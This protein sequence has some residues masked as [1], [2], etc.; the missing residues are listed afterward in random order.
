MSKEYCPK[1]KE[2]IEALRNKLRERQ[3][4]PDDLILRHAYWN[5]VLADNWKEIQNG[6]GSMPD[7]PLADVGRF[8]D[9]VIW[10][11]ACAVSTPELNGSWLSKHL[12]RYVVEFAERL[13]DVRDNPTPGLI[14]P[15]VFEDP[16]EETEPDFE[17]EVA[18]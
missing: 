3:L 10:L 11:S 12:E 4:R 16:I 17:E 6:V 5:K 18:A 1:T 8:V 2:Q 7:D 9:D 15:K 13:L 14:D